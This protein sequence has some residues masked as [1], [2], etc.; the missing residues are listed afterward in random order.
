MLGNRSG[1]VVG[2]SDHDAQLGRPHEQWKS[3][4]RDRVQRL[5]LSS[6]QLYLNDGRANRKHDFFLGGR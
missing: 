6:S 5:L 2:K 1:I 4:G 3:K